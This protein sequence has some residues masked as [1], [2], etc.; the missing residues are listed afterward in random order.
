MTKSTAHLIDASAFTVVCHAK[1]GDSKGD[2]QRNDSKSSCGPENCSPRSG[3]ER[4]HAH[5]SLH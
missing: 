3:V 5:L 1:T 2:A 4:V